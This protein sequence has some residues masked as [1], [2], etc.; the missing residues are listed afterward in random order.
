M[1]G[2][3]QKPPDKK[4]KID[5]AE[6]AIRKAE[7]AIQSGQ[8]GSSPRGGDFSSTNDTELFNVRHNNP[9]NVKRKKKV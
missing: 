6:K 9:R 4:K 5:D 1:F 7:A 3:E 8:D 2:V